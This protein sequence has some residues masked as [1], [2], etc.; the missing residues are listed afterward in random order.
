ME[1]IISCKNP[2]SRF[3]QVKALFN[4]RD[5]QIP[6]FQLPSW[7]PGRYELGNFAKNLRGMSAHTN[8]KALPITKISKDRWIIPDAPAGLITLE[9]EYYAAQ[10]DAGACWVDDDI[11]YINPVHC[12]IYNTGEFN[13]PCTVTADIPPD[14]KIAS[15]LEIKGNILSALNFDQLADSP[16]FISPNLRHDYYTENGIKFHIWFYGNGQPDF[17]RIKKD[18][19]A[20]TRVQLGMMESFPVTD[21]HFLVLLLPYPFYHGV[22]HKSST[23]LALGPGNKI[24]Q[25]ELYSSLIGVA[26][27]ELFHVW[28][29]K[30]LRPADFLHYDFTKENYSR[31]GWVYEGFTTYYGDLF[32]SRSGYFSAKDFLK[33]LDIRLQKHS[34]NPAVIYSTVT[35]S[36][37]DTWLD[38]Y[39]KGVP[40][41]KTSIYDEG[42]L[43]ALMLDLFIRRESKNKYSLDHL[44]RK[45]YDDFT[46]RNTGYSEQDIQRLA[47]E[48][49]GSSPRNI[50]NLLHERKSYIPLLQELLNSV[51]CYISQSVPQHLHEKLYGFKLQNNIVIQVWPGSPA[52]S[53]GIAVDDHLIACNEEKIENDISDLIYGDKPDKFYLF[54]RKKLKIITMNADGINYFQKN[55]IALLTDATKQQK[56]AFKLWCGNEFTL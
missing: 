38:G 31:L 29:V 19:S 36:S 13:A 47:E 11:I 56:E 51:G 21:Y 28:N 6:E 15:S 24:M 5:S 8:G 45:L 14:W 42:C 22:E 44:F 46:E 52:E 27:H 10:P 12:F 26:S 35:E 50:F 9:Y 16:F 39:V 25:P 30:T 49:A 7:R 1:Y 43:I 54:S 40:G 20:F 34:D 48:L 17:N 2:A 4:N 3:I 55:S 33:E 53:A 41:R 18:F 32:L 23:V 37:F